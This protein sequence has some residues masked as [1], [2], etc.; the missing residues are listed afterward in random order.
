M[1][2]AAAYTNKRRVMAEAENTKVEQIGNIA[3]NYKLLQSVLPSTP[4]VGCGPDFTHYTYFK[5]CVR[6]KYAD[7]ILKE[8]VYLEEIVAGVL[9][10]GNSTLD[11]YGTNAKFH[12]T[13]G[14][15]NTDNNTIYIVDRSYQLIR[16]YLIST[17]YVSTFAG[18]DGSYGSTN[19]TTL[20]NSSFNYPN[21]IAYDSVNNI[22]Y[23]SESNDIRKINLNTNTI[24]TLLNKP[25]GYEVFTSIIYKNNFIYGIDNQK[26]IIFKI[27]PST[28]NITILA[29]STSGGKGYV[30]GTGASVRFNT[31]LLSNTIT[32]DSVGNLYI[33]DRNNNCIRKLNITTNEV[34]TFQSVSDII[35]IT[36]NLADGLLYYV[37]NNGLYTLNLSTKE[38]KKVFQSKYTLESGIVII[39]SDLFY[40]VSP[41]SI[42]IKVYRSN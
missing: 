14:L 30:D 42:L 28:S 13:F 17:N 21:N 9:N 31:D 16:K 24:T 38:I 32:A 12:S 3:T 26:S 15:A 25:A 33:A 27:D 19:G 35:T 36:Y 37:S 23:I 10:D 18:Q 22:M 39:N 7:C 6:S 34:T 1:K 11:G 40:F 4:S 29:G 8:S 2:S 5:G 20:L 41:N